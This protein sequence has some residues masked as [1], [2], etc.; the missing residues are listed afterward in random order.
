MSNNDFENTSETRTTTEPSG[1]HSA[2]IGFLV[3]GLVLALAGDGYLLMRTS[4]SADDMA[5]MREDT[6]AQISRVN[7][8]TAAM[9]QEN[10]DR[11]AA[12]TDELKGANDSASTA[13]KRA[14]TE[15][16]RQAAQI[17][18]KLEDENKQV[19]DEL[20]QLKDVTTSATSKLTEVSTDVDGVK[21]DVNGV[22]A[23]VA[24]THTQLDQTGSDLKRVM[25]DMGVMSGLVATNS[26][27]LSALRELGERNYFEFD[28]TKKEG[29]KKIGDITLAFR[30]AD[31][32]HNRY[33]VDVLAD[34]KHLE[35]RD[36]TINEPVQLYVSGNSQP[37]EIVINQVKKDEVIGYLSTPK[38]KMARR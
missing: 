37:Y 31:P 26:K 14:R 27:D 5:A 36:K 24:S 4:H 17:A 34:D 38:V 22:K 15:A 30:K 33:T 7:D 3:G 16:Q 10:R 1:G 11:L 6:K 21:T 12:L 13:V 8:A 2:L 20:S 23:D 35:K 18:Q 29:T 19:S 25:G 9:L 28:L 32:K